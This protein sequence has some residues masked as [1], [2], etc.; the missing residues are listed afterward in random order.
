[1]ATMG[2]AQRRLA[3]SLS[4]SPSIRQQPAHGSALVVLGM[5]MVAVFII[6]LA[7]ATGMGSP[8]ATALIGGP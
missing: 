8:D 5:L 1:M 7:A 2:V 4:F 3:M 6:A